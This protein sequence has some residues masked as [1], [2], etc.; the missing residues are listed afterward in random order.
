MAETKNI[1]IRL[2]DFSEQDYEAGVNVLNA[3]T[4]DHLNSVTNWK[5]FDETRNKKFLHQRVLVELDGKPIGLGVYAQSEWSYQPGKYYI[6]CG[7]DPNFRGRGM[8]SVLY[9]FILKKLDEFGDVNLLTTD[10]RE[11]EPD[12]IRF[13]EKRGF[14]QTIREPISRLDVVS[15]DDS[16][17]ETTFQCVMDANIKLCA[18]A[19]LQECDPNCWRK[20][21]ELDW[22]VTQ[23]IPSS[24]PFT[25]PEYETYVN[26]MKD[27]RR[28]H[29]PEGFVIAVAPSDTD[30]YG[31]YVGLSILHT[32]EANPTKLYTNVTG[33][34]RSHRRMGIATAMKV[35]AI[36]FAR[37]YGATEIETENEENNP[38][39]DLN[40]AL[41]F[42]E[43]TAYLGYR[44]VY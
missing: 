2:F 19:E 16:R 20:I 3:C 42:R 24:S 32:N 4:P 10:T 25:K 15:F 35:R 41:G 40:A 11:D 33:V 34:L 21:Y 26:Q 13:L 27:T 8:G 12:T 9:D 44:K 28:G 5:S 29:H 17:F 38:M 43:V 1:N 18:V 23:D 6:Y 7:I 36:Q 37:E 22:A 39:F 30:E 31:D 14:V